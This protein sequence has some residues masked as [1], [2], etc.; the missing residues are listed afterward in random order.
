VLGALVELLAAIEGSYRDRKARF[1]G[2]TLALVLLIVLAI[3][4]G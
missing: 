4:F 3:W 2:M 1:I